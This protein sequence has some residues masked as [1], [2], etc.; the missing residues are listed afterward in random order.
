MRSVSAPSRRIV[1]GAPLPP[2]ATGSPTVW[3]SARPC[4]SVTCAISS[5]LVSSTI[6][7]APGAA[8]TLSSA[9]PPTRLASKSRSRSSAT[10]VT[11]ATWGCAWVSV[12]TAS[13]EVRIGETMRSAA[14]ATGAGAASIVVQ[15]VLV[16]NKASGAANLRMKGLREGPDTRPGYLSVIAAAWTGGRFSSRPPRAAGSSGSR[17]YCRRS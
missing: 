11:R 9:V 16:S 7:S 13:G 2:S 15:A 3:D 17:R 14:A 12:S 5:P 4:P 8:S 1:S 6:S 10:C